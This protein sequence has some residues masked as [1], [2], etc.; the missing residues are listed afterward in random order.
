[1]KEKFFE[2]KMQFF[3]CK[4]IKSK[5]VDGILSFY[6]CHFKIICEEPSFPTLFGVREG[7]NSEFIISD[8]E[9]YVKYGKGHV[10]TLEANFWG[11][12]FELLNSGVKFSKNE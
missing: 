2:V 1:M 8:R 4:V 9:D 3:P 12:G 7:E 10:A 11:T 5:C 6:P